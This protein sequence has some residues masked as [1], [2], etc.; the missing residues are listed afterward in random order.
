MKKK[1]FLKGFTPL[2][3]QRSLSLFRVY[4]AK[5]PYGLAP[6][7]PKF[8]VKFLTG[9]TLIELLVV[10]SIIGLLTSIIFVGL[11]SAKEK[12]RVA[13]I[14]QFSESIY[15]GLGADAIGVWNFDENQGDTALDSSGNRNNGVISG[16]SYTEETPHKAVGSGKGKYALNFDG[17][18]D[19]VSVPNSA[20]LSPANA[21]TAE[22]WIKRNASGG[23][24]HI[25]GKGSNGA[26]GYHFAM[27]GTTLVSI[28][29]PQGLGAATPISDTSKWYHIAVTWDGTTEK[30][31]VDG[32]L[33]GSVA[34]SSIGTYTQNLTIG[35]G[36]VAPVFFN[37]II[38]QVRIYNRA[39]TSFE[40]QRHY[41]EGA[42]KLG[43]VEK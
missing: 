40:I 1:A 28:I 2:E 21:V 24:R 22:A 6:F 37:G 8:K 38:D 11:S 16:A 18:D 34:V 7:A 31:Y 15:H 35:R 17:V 43:L 13:K 41:A 26:T 14:L 39:L 30:I 29:G 12:A 4:K 20:S 10:I 5:P 42:A 33:D 19:Y 32:V 27:V 9:F 23:E 25:L 36:S 3:I